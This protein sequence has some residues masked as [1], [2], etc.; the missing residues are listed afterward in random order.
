[1]HFLH[2]RIGQLPN[3]YVRIRIL[4]HRIFIFILWKLWV[5]SS[6]AEMDRSR[7]VVIY[8]MNDVMNTWR[9]F[10]C[11]L[12]LNQIFRKQCTFNNIPL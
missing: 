9:S 7:H 12:L 5:L 10:G 1:M 11:V 2:N 4:M 8:V 6:S 3:L